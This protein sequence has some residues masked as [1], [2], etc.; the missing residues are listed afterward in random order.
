MQESNPHYLKMSKGEHLQGS[1][2]AAST[3][4]ADSSEPLESPGSSMVDASPRGKM[5]LLLL[6][7]EISTNL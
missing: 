6:G 7:K 1:A 3:K 4:V 5:L 2:A